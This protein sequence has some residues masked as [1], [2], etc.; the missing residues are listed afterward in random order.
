MMT[1][2][3]A[4]VQWVWDFIEIPLYESVEDY[5]YLPEAKLYMDGFWVVGA[6]VLYTR[7]G[8]E[9]TFISTVNTSIVRNYTIY[10]KATFPDY[11]ITSI[12]PIVFSVVDQIPPVI[13]EIP[14]KT[15]M[16]GGAFPSFEEGVSYS[17]NYDDVSA[18]TLSFQTAHITKSIVGTYLYGVILTD[19]SGNQT[20]K[21]GTLHVVDLIPPVIT[22]KKELV[23]D[24]FGQWSINDFFTIIDNADTFVEVFI[25][26]HDVDYTKIGS[27]PIS[28]SV[29]DD[30]QNVTTISLELRIVDRIPPVLT[31]IP[32][33]PIVDV[34]SE[35]GEDLYKSYIL[36]TEDNYDELSKEDVT[37]IGIINSEFIGTYKLT[38]E[39]IDSSKNVHQVFL[40]VKVM[41]RT[42]PVIESIDELKIDV[43]SVEPFWLEY[44]HIQDNY[45]PTSELAVQLVTKPKM[46]VIGFYPLILTVTDKSLNKAIYQC[47]IEVVDRVSPIIRQLND[48]VITDFEKRDYVHYFELDDQY[49]S[50]ADISLMIDDSS[51]DYSKIGEYALMLTATDPSGNETLFET[52]LWLVDITE[53]ILTL[54][55]S[56]F[57]MEYGDEPIILSDFIDEVDDNYDELTKDDVFITGDANPL[58]IGNYMIVYELSDYSNNH[59]KAMLNIVIDD[60]ERPT[61]S[62][63]ELVVTEGSIINFYEGIEGYDNYGQPNILCLNQQMTDFVPGSYVL[64]YVVMDVRGNYRIYERTLIIEPFNQQVSIMNYLPVIIITLL[65]ILASFFNY[66]YYK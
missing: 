12:H 16:V 37:V 48:I 13:H 58:I 60:H 11:N 42:P 1:V 40:D 3:E 4:K 7:N 43:F 23:I 24:I 66:R 19:S 62:F 8:V 10:Y 49:Y 2:L 32:T 59:T 20:K 17:D 38:Y 35:V 28:I 26:D 21:V 25:E 64:T 30:S 5:R 54:T 45:S 29:V 44:F 34:F 61:L 57:H 39:L 36:L 18:L 27:Y 65:G 56:T 63:E 52:E 9:R 47:Y 33:S 46:D 55:H 14:E 41:D 51:V 50:T 22:Q 15:M 6:E 31:L 53:P